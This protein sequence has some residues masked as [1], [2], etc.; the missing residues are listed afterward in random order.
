MRNRYSNILFAF[1]C[2]ISAVFIL[3]P[4][5]LRFEY[6]RNVVSVFFQALDTS[7]YKTAYI[8]GFGGLLG[9]FLAITGSLWTQNR[10]DKVTAEKEVE[11]TASILYYEL[12]F[13]LRNVRL[14][15]THYW[16]E[17]DNRSS[18]LT[19]VALFR[20]STK[21]FQISVSDDWKKY[22][23]ILSDYYS[24]SEIETLHELYACLADIKL[25][26]NPYVDNVPDEILRKAYGRTRRLCKI[27]SVPNSAPDFT[28]TFSNE[29]NEILEKTRKIAQIPQKESKL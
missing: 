8:G 6:I 5:L 19:D 12:L 28:I 24:N 20:R 26:L 18:K 3:S 1:G 27:S 25:A 11:Q 15:L 14:L 7:E 9:T 17:T 2:C 13:A 23:A 29:V 16:L 21:F 4:L 22:I 10:I